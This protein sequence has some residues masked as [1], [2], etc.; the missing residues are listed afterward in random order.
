M[1]VGSG[2]NRGTDDFSA[3][4]F[5]WVFGSDPDIQRFSRNRQTY[6]SEVFDVSTPSKVPLNE[7]TNLSPVFFSKSSYLIVKY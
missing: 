6:S 1:V 4:F 7:E 3:R 5:G 2:P